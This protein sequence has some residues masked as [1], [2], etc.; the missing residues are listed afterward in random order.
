MMRALLIVAIAALAGCGT[1][2]PAP[3]VIVQERPQL[4]S[5]L[6]EP[7]T[8]PPPQPGALS[9][10]DSAWAYVIDVALPALARCAQ[11]KA[12]LVEA[13]MRSRSTP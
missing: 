12:G 7:C 13:C 4:D 1:A 2:P 11:A 9:G 5:V 8:L 10:Y 3:H 6:V